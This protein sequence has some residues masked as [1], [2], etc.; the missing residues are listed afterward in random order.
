MEIG[1]TSK[2][3]LQIKAKINSDEI[4]IKEVN[5]FGNGAKI[6]FTKKFIGEKVLVIVLQNGK[7]NKK[8]GRKK[9]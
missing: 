3:L 9:R 8:V 4:H 2:N 6:D 7:P 5:S 1:R